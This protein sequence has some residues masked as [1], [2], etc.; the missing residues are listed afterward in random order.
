MYSRH[1]SPPAIT[2]IDL[3]IGASSKTVVVVTSQRPQICRQGWG[4]AFL[5]SFQPYREKE[6]KQ[7]T[8]LIKQKGSGLS[9]RIPAYIVTAV[10]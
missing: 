3:R 6:H 9:S 4:G 10:I 8:D 2:V 7:H 1:V 5:T